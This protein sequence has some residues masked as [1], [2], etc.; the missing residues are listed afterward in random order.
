MQ[1]I[2]DVIR[3]NA[4][5]YPDKTCLIMD[6][7]SMTYSQLNEQANRLARGLLGL[8]VGPGDK[9]AI[10]AFN[11]LE[12][13]IIV[14]AIAKTGATVVPINFRY[15]KDELVYV[16]NNSEPKALLYGHEF[17]ELIGQSKP[18]FELPLKL[19]SIAGG[20]IENSI[21]MSR[22]MDGQPS[23]E[24]E[25]V[26]DPS[27]PAFI[28]YT[29][30][31]TGFPKGTLF[32]HS[33][34]IEIFEGMVYEG[35]L[36]YDDIS[37]VCIPLFHNGGL[38]GVLQPTLTVGATAVVMSK[39]FDAEKV[40]DAVQRYKITTT[41]WVPT[42][43]TMLINYP[44]VTKWDTS[45]LKKIY[46]GSSAITPA[47][48]G[49]SMNIFRNVGFYQWYGQVETGM[50]SVL[51]PEDHRE[52]SQCTGREM[53]NADLRIVDEDGNE[54]GEGQTGEIISAQKPLGMIGY[55]RMEEANA[56]TIRDGWIHTG[57]VARVEGGGYFTIVDRI[58]DMIISGA[59]N[60]YPKEIEDVLSRHEGVFEAAVFG[61]P[62]EVYGEA[63]CA[64]VV[65]KQGYQLQEQGIIEFCASRMS[66]YKKPKRVVF[67]KELPK[68]AT[69][70]VT[71]NV[72]REPYWAGRGKRV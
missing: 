30:G 66:G 48:L 5:R 25:V 1:V 55:Y 29:S 36:K 35:D 27:T 7:R 45:S 34:Y 12:Y 42:Q 56:S 9:V 10:L 14:Y 68:N 3:L 70:K 39:G 31:T 38:N 16:V 22:I 65:A 26:V 63:V 47:T 61:I 8:G 2:G 43:L 46:Y 32:S 54:V 37:L 24:P 64:V 41:M 71:K 21:Q 15:K 58:K 51:R 33:A 13:P 20:E 28:M 60:I 6:E 50:V 72:L 11:C 4:K 59:E 40:L 44:N 23:S 19:I 69:G 17:E 53:F 49:G 52:R 57:D 62:D 67:V 18:S